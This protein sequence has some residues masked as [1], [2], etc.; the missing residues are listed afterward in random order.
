MSFFC[1]AYFVVYYLN[2]SFSRLLTSV[3]EERAG[4]SIDYS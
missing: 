1:N 2:A 3:G 4:F